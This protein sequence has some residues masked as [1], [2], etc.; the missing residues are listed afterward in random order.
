MS[1]HSPTFYIFVAF[2]RI[3]VSCCIMCF[4][5]N[6]V[7]YYIELSDLLMFEEDCKE[8]KVRTNNQ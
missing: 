7:N 3:E 2:M 4:L 6:I 1:Q 5:K 8:E